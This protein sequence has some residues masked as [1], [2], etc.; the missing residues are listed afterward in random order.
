MNICT[1]IKFSN[2]NIK[3]MLRKT[4]CYTRFLQSVTN[5]PR[6]TIRNFVTPIENEPSKKNF[7]QE[8]PHNTGI[9]P[10]ENKF[11]NKDYD[12][13]V[14]KLILRQAL[15]VA[16]TE[17]WSMQ[18]L[19]KASKNIFYK[20][21]SISKMYPKGPIEL[22]SFM[23]KQWISELKHEL[24]IHKKSNKFTKTSDWLYFGLKWQLLK[25]A[26]YRK[27]WYQVLILS[28]EPRNLIQ[29]LKNLNRTFDLLYKYAD[30]MQVDLSYYSQRIMLMTILTRAEMFLMFDNSPNYEETWNFLKK[31]IDTLMENQDYFGWAFLS[32]IDI[33]KYISGISDQI[34]KLINN[35]TSDKNKENKNQ[36]NQ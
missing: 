4:L 28:L 21:E 3:K 14:K 18:T 35:Q 31:Q 32:A 19:E 7:S 36:N 34:I 11:E 15:E 5:F 23:R 8:P 17:G 13:L 29:S 12:E 24:E 25:M 10:S 30:S 6:I 20:G 16:K 27:N 33:P 22:I 26:P 9:N 1:H 2:N